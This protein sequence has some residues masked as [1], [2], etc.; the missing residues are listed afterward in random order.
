MYL[1]TFSDV[2]FTPIYGLVVLCGTVIIIAPF[3]AYIRYAEFIKHPK[4]S[5]E[6]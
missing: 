3:F 6:I 1:T 5:S 2:L 4:F